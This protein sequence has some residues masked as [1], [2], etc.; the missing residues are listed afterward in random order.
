MLHN[1]R[2]RGTGGFV[3]KVADSIRKLVRER[4]DDESRVALERK[5]RRREVAEDEKRKGA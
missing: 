1:Q 3:G 5:H 2:K 4:A